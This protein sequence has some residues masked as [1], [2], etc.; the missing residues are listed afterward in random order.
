MDRYDYIE[1][2]VIYIR[3]VTGINFQLQLK[4]ILRA[5]YK[6]KG[7]TYGMPDFYGG[8]Q[9]NDGWVKEN[10]TFYQIFAPT[11]LKDSLKT[12]I[13]KKFKDDLEGLL[14]IVYKEKKW[15]GNINKFI[16]IVN[17]ID[18]NLPHDSNSYFDNLVEKLNKEYCINIDHLVSNCDYIRDLL[19]EIDDIDVLKK[20]SATLRI[21][22]I[23]DY[24]AVSETLIISL[25]EEISGNISHQYLGSKSFEKY[26]RVSSANKIIINKLEGKKEEIENIIE[27]L[28][29]VDKAINVINQDI[30]FENKFDR[31]K[32]F[33]INKYE[34]LSKE[35]KGEDLYKILISETLSYTNNN[36]MA[37]IP[38]KFLIIYIFD[39][40][41]IFE[42]EEV[43]LSDIT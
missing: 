6:Y 13:E 23:V 30:L 26:Q 18:G 38:M 33:I 37:E 14:K 3:S 16:F 32:N 39:K 17:T 22:S 7:L 1:A 25:I 4:D 35:Y 20:I 43:K 15:K 29:I 9:K 34:D 27:K 41:D 11:R 21:K 28:D 5:Y 36:S 2:I 12:E 10:A 24:N 31:V 8:D 42:K 40:C 19:E